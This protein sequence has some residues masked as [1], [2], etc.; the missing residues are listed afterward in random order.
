MSDQYNNI[1]YT[2]SEHRSWT[3]FYSIPVLKGILNEQYLQHFEGFSEALWLLLLDTPTSEDVDRAEGLLQNFCK[4]FAEY[5]GI[6][7]QETLQLYKVL[8]F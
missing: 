2:A 5:Y 4:K 8:L 1:S 3:L 7:I 6:V